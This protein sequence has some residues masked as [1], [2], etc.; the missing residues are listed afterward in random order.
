[1]EEGQPKLPQPLPREPDL[2]RSTV[3]VEADEIDMLNG[4][5][6]L[7]DR[8]VQT[9]KFATVQATTGPHLLS[10]VTHLKVVVDIDRSPHAAQGD[11]VCRNLVVNNVPRQGAQTDS[12]VAPRKK[13]EASGGHFQDT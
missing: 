9:L 6:D 13:T 3:E 12:D 10:I 11:R 7:M 1:M 8:E 5:F 4:V 2:M